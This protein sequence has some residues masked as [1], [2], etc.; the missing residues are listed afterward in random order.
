[1]VVPDT[2]K[3]QTRIVNA[4]NTWFKKKMHKYGIKVPMTVEEA[5]Q[6]D[7]ETN[8]D[9]WHQAILKEMKKNTVAFKFLEEGEHVPVG[10]TWI[11]F[12]MIFDVKCNLTR[13]ARFVAG[14]TGHKHYRR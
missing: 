1:M 2:I 10:S 11:L 3:R 5:Y 7:K 8:T 6:I 13:K 9:Y 14:D 4:V 12:H